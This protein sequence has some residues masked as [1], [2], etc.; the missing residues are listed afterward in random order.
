MAPVPVEPPWLEL[1]PLPVVLVVL[2]VEL[3]PPLAVVEVVGLVPP[4]PPALVVVVPV[5]PLSSP[6]QAQASAPLVTKT[7]QVQ[8]LIV[9]VPF[10]KPSSRFEAERD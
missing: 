1:P 4:E 5:P 10:V 3:L 8:F 9:V 6:P 7:I 2:V